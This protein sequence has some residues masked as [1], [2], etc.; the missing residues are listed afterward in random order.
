VLNEK[1][2]AAISLQDVYDDF[3]ATMR[4]AAAWI[5]QAAA[6][7]ADLAVLPETINLLNR[8]S[9]A[10]PLAECALEDWRS[11]AA[12]LCKAAADAEIALA[13]PLLVRENGNLVNRFYLL[14]KSGELLGHYDKVALASAEREAGVRGSLHRPI[15]WEGLKLGGAICFDV[16]Y[17]QH[18][19]AP[20]VDLGAD[21]FVIPSYTPAGPLLDAY[22][23]IYG[24][25]M[26]L[27][28][29]QWNRIL[30]RNGR[31]L[32]SGGYR[33]ETLRYGFG[34]AIVQATINFDSVALFADAN[35]EKM[36]DIQ[37][38]YGSKIRVRFDQPSCVF[39]L[40][41]RSPDLTVAELMREFD[42]VSRRDYIAR[43]EPPLSQ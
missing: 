7:G 30:D 9:H 37:S 33:Q 20:Q 25:P 1:N 8:E 27:A 18:V 13:L 4:D 38:R 3:A 2:I 15:A 43:N 21:F 40:E 31:E 6:D 26:I 32:A 39:L 29:S 42:L 19:F 22:A 11:A 28:Y 23:L 36:R 35:Q 17:P 10:L 16:Y 12:Q 14:A 41:S 5:K 24:V 34:S